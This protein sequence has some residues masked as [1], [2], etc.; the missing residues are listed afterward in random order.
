MA[1]GRE[2]GGTDRGEGA[3]VRVQE[4]EKLEGKNEKW[5]SKRGSG[6]SLEDGKQG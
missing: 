4:N 3:R 5:S 6:R 1:G 2:R